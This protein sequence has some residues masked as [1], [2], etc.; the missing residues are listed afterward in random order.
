MNEAGVLNFR[1][2]IGGG[3]ERQTF[4][5]D[6]HPQCLVSRKRRENRHL[7]LLVSVIPKMAGLLPIGEGESAT[8]LHSSRGTSH[9]ACYG[10]GTPRTHLARNPSIS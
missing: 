8:I 9:N 6:G 2:T 10:N 1:Q 7:R 5:G 4:T 3:A